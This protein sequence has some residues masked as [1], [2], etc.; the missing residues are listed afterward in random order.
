MKK[1]VL[2][3]VAINLLATITNVTAAAVVTDLEQSS[4]TSKRLFSK[5][6]VLLVTNQPA[7]FDNPYY[8][9][10]PFSETGQQIFI[11]EL[12]AQGIECVPWDFRERNRERPSLAEVASVLR[13][14]GLTQAVIIRHDSRIINASTKRVSSPYLLYQ[15]HGFEAEW[16]RVEVTMYKSIVVSLYSLLPSGALKIDWSGRKEGPVSTTPSSYI[17]IN[18]SYVSKINDPRVATWRFFE[19]AAKELIPMLAKNINH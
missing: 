14:L 19:A 11:K 7:N 9:W 10:E 17:S 8:G 6:R 16:E 12:L 1:T 3:M 18:G 15:R 4:G 5:G 13:A 2:F